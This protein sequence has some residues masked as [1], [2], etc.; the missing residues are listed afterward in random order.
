M[1]AGRRARIRVR[2][3]AKWW[4]DLGSV[5]ASLV[6]SPWH[7]SA[8]F[9]PNRPR[10]VLGQRN[11]HVATWADPGGGAHTTAYE[12]PGSSGRVGQAR[13]TL[14]RGAVFAFELIN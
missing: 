3:Q 13:A 6:T 8:R 7:L 14:I 2:P 9:A 10:W 4:Y 1:A 11:W 5:V 12:A